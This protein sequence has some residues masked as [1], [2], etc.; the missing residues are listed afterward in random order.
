MN[1]NLKKALLVFGGG[2]ILF[3][4]FKKI[5]PVG[6]VKSK[7]SSSSSAPK[8]F[9]DEEKKNAAIVLSAYKAAQKAGESSSFLNQMNIEFASQYSMKVFPDKS[10]G[11]VFVADLEG[12]KIL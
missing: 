3:L 2:F 4:A 5:K 9:S 7:K 6:S 8:T 11:G 10:T 1:T 12:N